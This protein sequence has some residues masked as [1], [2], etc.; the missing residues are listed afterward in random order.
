M[1][2]HTSNQF[3]LCLENTLSARVVKSMDLLRPYR[4]VGKTIMF[5]NL[6]LSL[7]QIRLLC[8]YS[9]R[10]IRHASNWLTGRK[11]LAKWAGGVPHLVFPE[12][13]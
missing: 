13:V 7:G 12:E 4:A 2:T 11:Y 3:A 8:R 9:W 5:Q 10:V 1:R 6:K